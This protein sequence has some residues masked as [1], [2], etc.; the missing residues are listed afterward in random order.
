[1][2]ANRL[3]KLEDEFGLSFVVALLWMF[4]MGQKLVR[5]TSVCLDH[6]LWA[7]TGTLAPTIPSGCLPFIGTPGSTQSVTVG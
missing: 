5:Q 4:Q 7:E 1:M 6:R 2:E 3:D